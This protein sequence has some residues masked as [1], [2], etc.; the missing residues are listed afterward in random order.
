MSITQQRISS[1]I[2]WATINRP[3]ARNAIDFDV[4]D[5]LE[6]LVESL[7]KGDEIRVFILS[8]A[9]RQSFVAGGDLKKFHTIQS[10]EKAVEMSKRM[11]DIFNRIERLPCWTVACINGDAYG[12]GIELMLAFDFRVSVPDAKFGFTQGRFYLVP[13]WGGLTRL[14]EKAGK[15]KALQWCGKAE[16]LSAS[17]V[18]AHGLIEHILKGEDLENEVLEWTEKLTKNDRKFIQTLKA[19][20]SRFSHQR[21]ESLEA[22]VEPFAEL[23]VDAEH[24]QRVEKFMSRKNDDSG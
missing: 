10:K 2:L 8:G 11:H 16:I 17:S 20:A 24:I 19:G 7:E 1:H 4:M 6:Q 18:L 13:G 9:G 22:E 21:T 23:W 14:V 12:G 15:A 3:E 5:E